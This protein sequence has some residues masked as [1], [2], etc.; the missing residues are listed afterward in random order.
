[1]CAHD[2]EVDRCVGIEQFASNMEVNDPDAYNALLARLTQVRNPKACFFTRLR[3]IFGEGKPVA[4]PCIVELTRAAA[5][6]HNVAS[7][8]AAVLLFR[9][10]AGETL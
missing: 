3:V 9:A 6:G 8:M 4:R 2:P 5:K 7:Y 10:N 1:M